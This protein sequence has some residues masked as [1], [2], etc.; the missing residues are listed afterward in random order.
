MLQ[1]YQIVADDAG[2]PTGLFAAGIDGQ[3]EATATRT[4]EDGTALGAANDNA[5][6]LGI[7][8][9]PVVTGLDTGE[10]L[11]SWIDEKGNVKAQLFPPNGVWVP[12]DLAVNGLS[13]DNYNEATTGIGL[14]AASE[15][16]NAVAG[17]VIGT[18]T[19]NDIDV[20]HRASFELTDTAGGA[21]ALI[22]NQIVV[23]NPA[24]LDYESSQSK[25]IKVLAIDA[26]GL[27]VEKQIDISIKNLTNTA[28]YVFSG[29]NANANSLNGTTGNDVIASLGGD[30]TLDGNNGNDIL[31]GGA[32]KDNMTGGAG[33]DVPIA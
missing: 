1:R 3:V 13:A 2:E 21:F 15:N 18:L 4:N 14:S 10:T 29:G 28:D 6:E 19:A 32:G 33:D 8:R 30:D 7:G 26:G 22:G 24:L 31:D 16:E 5:I 25:T 9:D 11:V 27:S 23:A 20:G 12:S 17:T